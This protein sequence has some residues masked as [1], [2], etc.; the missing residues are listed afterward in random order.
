MFGVLERELKSI[1]PLYQKEDLLNQLTFAVFS[2]SEPFVFKQN[3]STLVL[4]DKPNL[5]NRDIEFNSVIN[6][7][8]EVVTSETTPKNDN[9]YIVQNKTDP[10]ELD[11]LGLTSVNLPLVLLE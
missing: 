2:A 5:V 11:L 8:R 4:I 1:N 9:S 10:I 7:T 6:R 3:K